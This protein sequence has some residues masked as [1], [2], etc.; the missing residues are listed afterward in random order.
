MTGLNVR[1]IVTLYT[2]YMKLTR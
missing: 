2:L 1:D